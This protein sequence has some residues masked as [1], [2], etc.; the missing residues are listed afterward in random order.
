M[1]KNSGSDTARVIAYLGKGGAGKTA[2]SALTARLL[3][4]RKKKLLMID[5]DPA[6]GLVLALGADY[7][8]TVG[9]ARDR[10]I[11]RARSEQGSG[12]EIAGMI[13]YLIL[14]ALAEHPLFSLLVMGRTEGPGCYCPVNTLLRE[15]IEQLAGGFDY[16]VIDAEAGI[17][18]VSRQVT[19]RVDRPVIVTDPSVR[20]AE[21]AAAI[22]EALEKNGSK[23]AAGVI[24]N[25]A[26]AP[27]PRLLERL[28]G[29]GLHCLG[30]VPSDPAILQ[31]DL[32][33]R[34]LLE[35]PEQSPALKSLEKV[36]ADAEII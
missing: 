31:F 5:A 17:E 19:K 9:Q 11:S 24:F 36:L 16:I 1:E 20:G 28:E 25:R 4:A 34:P 23:P 21:T 35:L 14:E 3:I 7:K 29:A 30:S 32:E 13:D 26:D 6:R 15:S 10:I 27:D 33:G 2:L 22:A 18:Q 12:E 8:Y